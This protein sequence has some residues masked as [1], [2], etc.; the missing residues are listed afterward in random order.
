[1]IEFHETRK[2]DSKLA[3]GGII[4]QFASPVVGLIG[5]GINSVTGMNMRQLD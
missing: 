5:H 4:H 3:S 2:F 1:M